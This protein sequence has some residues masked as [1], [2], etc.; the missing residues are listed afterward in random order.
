MTRT[1]SSWSV[2]RCPFRAMG[3]ACEVVLAASSVHDAQRLAHMAIDEVLRIERKYSR[4]TTESLIANI[5]QQAGLRPVVCDDETWALL[6]YASKLHEQSL[7]LFDIT[8]GVF[9]QAWN[10]QVPA[11]P[12]ADELDALRAKVGWHKVVLKDQSIALPFAGMEIDLGGFG[13]EYAADRAAQVLQAQGVVSGYVNL[14]GD[15]RFLGPKPTGEPWMIGIQDP[16]HANQVVA[17]LPITQGGLATSGDYERYF[18]WNGERYCHV[19]NPFTGRPVK[20]WRSVSVTAPAAVVAGCTSTM[21]MLKEE[22]GLAFL[23]ATGFDFLAID[24]AGKVHMRQ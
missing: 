23:Q 9:R 5:N 6:Q 20:F 16:R 18:E 11:I 10:F 1:V 19:L 7:G 24:H 12:S 14:A 22:E 15:M 2:H 17:T 4:Y 21:T 13:K 3:S 8:S